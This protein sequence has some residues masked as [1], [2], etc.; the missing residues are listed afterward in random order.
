ME[1]ILRY[2]QLREYLNRY[3]MESPYEE[4]LLLTSAT[5]S[6]SALRNAHRLGK[7][8]RHCDHGNMHQEQNFDE[9]IEDEDVPFDMPNAS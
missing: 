6:M 5:I 4:M 3:N 9:E 1:R 8:S 7:Y 2:R